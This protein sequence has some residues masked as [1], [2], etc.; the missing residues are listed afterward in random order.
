MTVADIENDI[1]RNVNDYIADPEFSLSGEILTGLT[2]TLNRM[3]KDRR[4]AFCEDEVLVTKPDFPTSDADE[5]PVSDEWVDTVINGTSARIL[6]YNSTD[7]ASMKGAEK[8]ELLF[9]QAIA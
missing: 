9:E 3:W 6:R 1:R 2:H 4:V 7:K 8:F 5:L